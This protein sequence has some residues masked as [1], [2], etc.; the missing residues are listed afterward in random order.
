MFIE[1][2]SSKKHLFRSDMPGF[3]GETFFQTLSGE[4]R[5]ERS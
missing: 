3:K 4:S 1:M 2:M 5:I